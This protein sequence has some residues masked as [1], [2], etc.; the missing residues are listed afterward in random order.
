MSY[1]IGSGGPVPTEK[2]YAAMDTA[3]REISRAADMTASIKGLLGLIRKAQ[4]RLCAHLHP[5]SSGDDAECLNDLLYML[6]GP[7]QRTIEELAKTAI[8]GAPK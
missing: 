1:E 6:D 7:E 8:S 5:D 2:E 4:E 3:A